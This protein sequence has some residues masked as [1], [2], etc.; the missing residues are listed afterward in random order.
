MPSERRATAPSFTGNFSNDK[1]K[2]KNQIDAKHYAPLSEQRP[3]DFPF[4]KTA[5]RIEVETLDD[6]RLNEGSVLGGKQSIR[7]HCK[8]TFPS[9][10]EHQHNAGVNWHAERAGGHHAGKRPP[11]PQHSLQ[12]LSPPKTRP[13]QSLSLYFD[14]LSRM[15]PSIRDTGLNRDDQEAVLRERESSWNSVFHRKPR[16]GEKKDPQVNPNSR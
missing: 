11:Y 6:D 8:L 15:L 5:T 2:N 4:R 12:G 16:P 1:N 13:T 3:K 14:S 10:P 9:N 7:G